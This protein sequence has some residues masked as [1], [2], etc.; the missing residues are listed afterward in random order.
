MEELLLH[1]LMH[2]VLA[3]V[4]AIAVNGIVKRVLVALNLVVGIPFL[5][6]GHIVGL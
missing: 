1:H 2:V 3:H 4:E 5:Q 6:M